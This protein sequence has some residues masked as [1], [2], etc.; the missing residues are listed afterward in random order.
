[1]S[2][3]SQIP[4][5]YNEL[6]MKWWR[7]GMKATQIKEAFA[8]EMGQ[9]FSLNSV[10]KKLRALRAQADSQTKAIM[11]VEISQ[12]ISSNMEILQAMNTTLYAEYN[13]AL[14]SKD[15]PMALKISSE[16]CK[17]VKNSLDIGMNSQIDEEIV[18]DHK[19]FIAELEEAAQ[20]IK[21]KEKSN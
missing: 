10:H 13:A 6:M 12:N 3:R 19:R 16:L 17:W 15:M 18:E 7:D 11:A 4:E 9:E 20:L 21:N 2:R 8:V 1:M 14:A 5:K